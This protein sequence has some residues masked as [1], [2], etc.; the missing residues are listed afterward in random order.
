RATALDRRPQRSEAGGD[1]VVKGRVPL[2]LEILAELSRRA[3]I[4]EQTERF[5][6]HD[7]PPRG[8]EGSIAPLAAGARYASS[9]AFCAVSTSATT[10]SGGVLSSI[11]PI[12]S[13][14]SPSISYRTS[15]ARCLNP[16]LRRRSTRR[17]GSRPEAGLPRRRS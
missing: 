6:A 15:A 14:R 5:V 2:A 13:Q 8:F 3:R 4:I 9:R 10:P 17:G 1:I 16:S 11:L 12:A 7:T